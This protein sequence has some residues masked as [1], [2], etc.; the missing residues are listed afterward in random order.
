MLSRASYHVL[1][2]HTPISAQKASNQK[3]HLEITELS[4]RV[5]FSHEGVHAHKS[6][7]RVVRTV[8]H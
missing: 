2:R 8:T 3:V 1:R 6:V 4:L 5:L 7:V